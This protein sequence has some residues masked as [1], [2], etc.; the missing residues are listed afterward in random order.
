[1]KPGQ[2]RPSGAEASNAGSL[3][4]VHAILL[5]DC[6][7]LDL[8][9]YGNPAGAGCRFPALDCDDTDPLINPGSKEGPPGAPVCKDGMDNDCDGLID[10]DDSSCSLSGPMVDIPPGCFDMGDF[11]AEGEPT[12]LPVHEVCVSAFRMDVHEVTNAEYAVCVGQGACSPPSDSSSCLRSSYYGNRDYRGFPVIYVNWFQ[13]RQYCIW[14]GKRLPT[15]AEWEFAARGGLSHKR[16]PGGDAI[17][18]W[19]AN[20]WNSGDPWDNDTSVAAYYEPNGFGLYD[21]AG[22]VYEWVNDW[23]SSGYYQECVQQGIR[24]DPPG[25]ES[26][27]YRGLRGG[28]WSSSTSHLRTAC[29]D[30][31]DPLNDYYSVG[32]RCAR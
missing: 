14:A 5:A 1:M 20:Y 16:Y 19:Q 12:E 8:D 22:N 10:Y 26:G 4:A 7:D 27:T 28:A 6:T 23:F 24:D 11:F 13:A 17:Y 9:G 25:P 2:E 30:S 21:M 15:E 31:F 3:P 29:R 18:E 32:F